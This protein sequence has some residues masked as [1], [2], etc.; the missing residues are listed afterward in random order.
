MKA[1]SETLS[2]LEKLSVIS[3]DEMS[4]AN[5]WRYDEGTDTLYNPHER[6]QIVMLRGFVGKWKQSIYYQFDESNM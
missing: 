6:V 1:K 3:V 4:I 2:S 5:E